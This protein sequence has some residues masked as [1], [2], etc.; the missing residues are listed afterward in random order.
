MPYKSPRQE[1]REAR[2]Q[3]RL[4]AETIPE[5]GT[6]RITR[7]LLQGLVAS[8]DSI[9]ARIGSPQAVRLDGETSTGNLKRD[10]VIGAEFIAGLGAGLYEM[11]L[12][13]A[14]NTVEAMRV[15]AHTAEEVIFEEPPV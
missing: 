7:R 4:D 14:D 10:L 9:S 8:T 12:H 13:A 3:Q 5:Y 2:I 6:N 15:A 1:R 11:A